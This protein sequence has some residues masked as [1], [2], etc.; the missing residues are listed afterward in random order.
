MAFDS[1]FRL[2]TQFN[3]N[4]RILRFDALKISFR[5]FFFKSVKSSPTKHHACKGLKSSSMLVY[6]L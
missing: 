3:K 5:R 4:I 1:G 2:L 6:L